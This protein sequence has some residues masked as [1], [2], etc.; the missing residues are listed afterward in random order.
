MEKDMLAW[1]IARIT[2]FFAR[3][4]FGLPPPCK[5][6]EKIFLCACFVRR[7]IVSLRH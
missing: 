5:A 3:L 6:K 1:K 4:T 7:L 2:C